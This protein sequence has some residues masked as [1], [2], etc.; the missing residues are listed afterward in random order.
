LSE[1]RL[2]NGGLPKVW[3]ESLEELNL[4]YNN[5]RRIPDNLP[6]S[7]RSLN[8]SDNFIETISNPIP[9]GLEFLNISRNKLFVVPAQL[10]G[11]PGLKLIIHTNHLLS[12]PT[13]PNI[14]AAFG[15]WVGARYIN[16]A[17]MIYW[18]W[19]RYR[20]RTRLRSYR[21]N[22]ML[23]HDIL[24]YAMHPDRMERYEAVWGKAT[25]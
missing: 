21:K 19:K 7:L 3:G 1:C 23:K 2:K 22:A 17:S 24:K 13:G 12:I 15:Q 4:R 25:I 8:V 10:L 18:A 6:E 9:A 5:L 16:A 11:R 14:L 20:L